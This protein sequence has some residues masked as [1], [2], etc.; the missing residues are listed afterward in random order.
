MPKLII[1]NFTGTPQDLV[2]FLDQFE[3]QIGKSNVDDVTKFSYLKE[4]L[5]IKVRRLLDGLPFTR[6]GYAKA[7]DVLQK[8]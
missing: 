3:S 7:R 2:R 1:S 6:E 4:L 8:R 5:D